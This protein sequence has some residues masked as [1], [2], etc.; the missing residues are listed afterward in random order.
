M[1]GLVTPLV[2]FGASPPSF[3][4]ISS[5]LY[6]ILESPDK[7]FNVTKLDVLLK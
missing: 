3:V 1:P 2:M 4:H 6:Y 5:A 7:D